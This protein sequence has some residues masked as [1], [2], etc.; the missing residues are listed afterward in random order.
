MGH[1]DKSQGLSGRRYGGLDAEERRAR[2]RETFLEAA[3]EIC[4]TAGR[5]DLTLRNVCRQ[6]G[7][8]E[9]YFYESFKD[10]DDLL[11]ALY[12]QL[13]SRILDT[14][15]A[16]VA[17]APPTLADQAR[18][19]MHAFVHAVADDVREARI[20]F[21]EVVGATPRLEEQRYRVTRDFARNNA[22]L[23]AVHLGVPVNTR[24]LTGAMVLTGGAAHTMAQWALGHLDSSLDEIADVI[25]DLFMTAYRQIE[26]EIA[27][28]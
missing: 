23:A 11:S 6:A 27:S 17:A 21:V 18:A 13:T 24:L 1:S 3:L 7:L 25:T 28:T 26:A 22:E 10:R 5:A 8:T 20:V 2:R 16:A 12:D 14:T 15:Y 4:G 9:R 19:G